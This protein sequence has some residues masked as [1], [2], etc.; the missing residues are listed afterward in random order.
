M[1]IYIIFFIT[2]F[3]GFDAV[4]VLSFFLWSSPAVA[5]AVDNKYKYKKYI[6]IWEGYREK[7]EEKMDLF[8]KDMVS[9]PGVGGLQRVGIRFFRVILM[10]QRGSLWVNDFGAIIKR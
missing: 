2:F 5:K 6:I 1:L 4:E 10:K 3:F 8:A 9:N 7:V